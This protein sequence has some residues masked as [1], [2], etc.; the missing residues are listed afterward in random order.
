MME[1]KTKIDLKNTSI[2]SLEKMK[3]N[4]STDKEKRAC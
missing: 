2:I 1:N 3:G 4:V